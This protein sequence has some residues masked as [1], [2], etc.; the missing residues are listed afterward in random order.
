MG[1][2]ISIPSQGKCQAPNPKLQIPT[3]AQTPNPKPPPNP[4]PKRLEVFGIWEL[5]V[6]WDLEL[7]A[8]DLT[9]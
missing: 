3:H 5:G 1:T 6:R 2:I 9:L 7:G 4:I 8:W